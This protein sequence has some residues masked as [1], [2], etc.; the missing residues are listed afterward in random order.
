[1]G[2]DIKGQQGQGQQGQYGQS[3]NKMGQGESS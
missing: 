2:Q 1:M 3:G